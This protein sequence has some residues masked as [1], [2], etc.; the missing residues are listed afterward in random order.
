M[1]IEFFSK[2]I[3]AMRQ[4]GA[5]A[6]IVASALIT[7]AERSLRDL[8]RDHSGNGA[9]SLDLD[10]SDVRIRQREILESIV[11]ILPSEKA[12]FP[13]NFLCCLLRSAIFLKASTG[14]KN[15]LEKR[16]SIILEHVT[17]DDLLVLSF[18]YD[19]ERLF[20]LDSV[21][22][23]IAGFVEKER[24][25]AVF[26]SGDF[27]EVCSTAMHRVAKTVDAYLAE[28]AAYLELAISKFNGIANLVPKGARKV[29]DDLYRAI[30]I[31]LKVKAREQRP[32]NLETASY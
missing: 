10:Q 26:N 23:I 24:N 16:I 28:I 4:R 27:R 13:I 5:K 14:C 12:A 19:G 15:E 22:R 32:P 17:V 8:V 31:Y 6:L 3:T 7:Y 29:D 11:A 18:T 1:D 9:N 2:V 30:D 21:R 20:D 25:M